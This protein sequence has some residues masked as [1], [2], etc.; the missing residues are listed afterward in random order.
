MTTAAYEQQLS[1]KQLYLDKLF[2]D[3]A[4]PPVQVFNSPASHYRMRAEFRIWHDGDECSYAMFTPGE[5]ASASNV[6]KL[7]HF[8]IAHENINSLMPKLLDCIQANELLKARLF[9]VEFLTT[10]AGD[11]LV[12][13]IYHKKLDDNWVQAARMLAEVLGVQILGRSR[14]QKVVLE[15]DYVIERL[16]VDN[17]VLQYKQLEGGFT[18]PNAI[19]C[20]YMLSW[21]TSVAQAINTGDL[22]ELYCGNGNF[23]LPL[24]RHFR[25]VLA[26]EVSKTSVQAARWNIKTNQINNIA[27]ARLSAEEFTEAYTGVRNFQR[28]VNEQICLSDYQFSTVF[29]DPPRAGIDQATLELLQKFDNIIYV[30]CNPVTLHENM[31]ILLT[32]HEVKRAAMFDQFPFT[33]H[34]ES[35]VWLQKR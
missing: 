20:Q 13:L 12:T 26:T 4:F 5:K 28:L 23:T 32:T 15:R 2:A 31:Q 7:R 24:S 3:C 22:L 33:P 11:T 9:Q 19:V 18:Q 1:D 34:I 30:S 8:S 35:G 16:T 17:K 21:A 10:L 27:L 29:V 14:G 6:H 25:C